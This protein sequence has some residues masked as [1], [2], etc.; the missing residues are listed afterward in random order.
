MKLGKKCFPLFVFSCVCVCM[1]C[2][3][4]H[5]CMFMPC[6]C[7]CLDL[8]SLFYMSLRV[9]I[10]TWV[11]VCMQVCVH[12][13][14]S[15]CSLP[16]IKEVSVPSYTHAFSPPLPPLFALS[17]CCSLY[18]H[19]HEC[20]HHLRGTVSLSKT[21]HV[22]VNVCVRIHPY[23]LFSDATTHLHTH[24]HTH[25]SRLICH[26]L[27]ASL[28]GLTLRPRTS[29]SQCL[30]PLW[31]GLGSEGWFPVSFTLWVHLSPGPS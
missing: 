4:V 21:K 31:S 3:I 13:A 2:V 1:W 30:R 18:S 14:Y 22:Y 11:I 29:F 28:I 12:S 6:L 10:C 17:L 24:T 16:N 7:K 23:V 27:C 8:H 19:D 15:L 25:T 26:S 5:V 20:S 9:Y